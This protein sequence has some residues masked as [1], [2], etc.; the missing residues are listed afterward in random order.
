V[1]QI[2]TDLANINLD[3]GKAGVVKDFISTL[4]NNIDVLAGIQGTDA[5]GAQ[6]W[7]NGIAE[8]ANKLDPEDANG[9]K[10]LIDTIKEG[11]PG[12]ENT[13]FGAA[14]FAALGDGFSDVEQKSSVLQ[15]AVDTLGNK[16]NRTAQEQAVWLETCR[17]LVKTI[18]G[19]SSIINTETG[20]IKGGTDA[21]KAYI[22]A[23]EDGQKKL[24]LMGA[25]QQKEDALSTRFA[26]LPGLELD[27]A[28]AKR[29]ARQSYEQLKKL[30][31]QYG[32]QLG[33]D[34]AGKINRNFNGYGN[35][36][37]NEDRAMLARET[38]YTE[39]LYREAEAATTAY[40]TQKDALDE[41]KAAIEEYRATVEEMPGAI[42]DATDAS[43]QFWVDNAQNI[44]AVVSATGEALQAL[45]DYAK[46]VHDAATEAVNSVAKSLNRVDYKA[47]GDQIKN[48]SDLTQKQAQY[49]VGSDEWKKLQSEID[50]A[51]ESLISTNNIYKNLETQSQFLGEYLTNLQKARDLGVDSNLL[52]ELSDGSVESAQYLDALVN[53]KTGK[54]VS[55]INALY[56]QVQGQK[57]ELSNELANQQLSVD[58]TYQSLADKAKEAV[59]ALDLQGEAAANTGKT[60]AGIASGIAEHVPDVS[61]QVDA[62]IAELDRLNGYGINIDFG[63]FG[64]IQFTTS[65]GKTEGSGRMGIPLV[66]HDDYIARLHEGERVLTAQE[67]QIWNAL[68]NG[69]IAGFDLE[70]LGGVMRD[71]VR[72]GGNVYL[73]GRTV[74]HVISDQQGKSYRQLQRSGWQS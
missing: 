31:E 29:R 67:N 16:T 46:G 43:E 59:A 64:S 24:A 30:Y 68:R 4:A 1:Q 8:S 5:E 42:E 54:T 51:N 6:E 14:F 9:W 21:V 49:K 27:M 22:Q 18:P 71:N 56:K 15:W 36:I 40:Q 73:D 10:T 63:G 28:L 55:E 60:I 37:S 66:P 74:G 23:W 13:D 72:A 26:E 2:A 62:I 69:G 25:V 65:A 20:E 39:Q 70:A 7:L 52:A 34:S 61:T 33:F 45:E 3:Q 58:Q 44:S 38:D 19:L 35:G 12:L 53:D 32:L 17:R 50:K 41:A 11:L 57:A 47:Y 48:I